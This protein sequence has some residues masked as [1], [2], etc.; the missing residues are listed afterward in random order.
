[1]TVRCTAH[2]SIATVL[3][4][5]ALL[6]AGSVSAQNCMQ[7][8]EPND[9]P[10]TANQLSDPLCVWGELADTDQDAF[11][12]TVSEEDA[13]RL[14]RFE[15]QSVPGQLTSVQVLRVEFAANGTD[16][17]DYQELF[18]VSTADGR[19][20]TSAPRLFPA[21]T[22][23]LGL[24]ISGGQGRYTLAL[25]GDEA[26][27]DVAP[28]RADEDGPVE[29]EGEFSYA[30][31]IDSSLE[32]DWTVSDEDAGYLWRTELSAAAGE[33]LNF[34]LFSPDGSQ[35]LVMTSGEAGLASV[36]S[37]GLEPGVHRLQVT[38][39]G[40]RVAPLR[41]LVARQGIATDGQEIE[42]NDEAATAN[43]LVPGQELSGTINAGGDTDWFSFVVDQEASATLFNLETSADGYL[44]L[45]LRQ[46][47]GTDVQCR[48]AEGVRLPELL[49]PEGQYSLW[50]RNRN[51]ESDIL[52]T[53]LLDP[54]GAPEEDGE[55]EPNDSMLW[56]TDIPADLRLRG[57][58]HGEETD[59]F[60]LEVTGEPQLWRA[61]VLGS[62][63]RELH[64]QRPAGG[65]L[66][67]ARGGSGPLQL[68]NLLL[69]PGT[70]YFSVK[71]SSGE[72]AFR[73][74]QLGPPAEATPSDSPL[75][76]G[77]VAEEVQAETEAQA[78]AE[79]APEPP[80]LNVEL[81]PNDESGYATP[82]EL[83]LPISG[84]V[85][86]PEDDDYFRFHLSAAQHVGLQFTPPPDGNYSLALYWGSSFIGD[87]RNIQEIPFSSSDWLPAGDYLLLVSSDSPSR[88]YYELQLERLDPFS[89]A[90][91]RETAYPEW[92]VYREDGEAV[93]GLLAVIPEVAGLQ[94]ELQHSSASPAAAY[95]PRSQQLELQLT[96]VNQADAE[97]ELQLDWHSSDHRWSLELPDTIT[98]PA[99]GQEQLSVPLLIDPDARDQ[100]VVLTV[101]ARDAAGA[102][103]T[104]P[105][106]LRA[107]GIAEPVASH[108]TWP[109]PQELL[110]GLNAAWLDLGA[111]L[112]L[113]GPG[114][115]EMSSRFNLLEL[116]N[117]MT[118][119]NHRYYN[120]H[121]PGWVTAEY[122]LEAFLPTVRLAGEE[123]VEVAG[124]LLHP[125]T[126]EALPAALRDFRVWLSPDGI[127]YVNVLEGSL[128]AEQIEQAFVLPEPVLARYA[129][130]EMHNNHIP[131]S[132]P[133]DGGNIRLGTFKV[134][135][136]LESAR[137]VAGS[138]G[139]NLA[140]P[141]LGGHLVWSDPPVIAH[142]NNMLRANDDRYVAARQD[143]EQE[144][145]VW[146]IAFHHNRA[147]QV[148]EFHWLDN[149]D[150]VGG[151][152][153]LHFVEIS[154]ST[155]GPDGPWTDLGQWVL[156][157]EDGQP[158]PF[159][160][161]EPAWARF[162]RFRATGLVP[163]GTYHYADE[164][165]VIERL[166]DEE[167]AS[168]LGEWGHYSSLGLFEYLQGQ[169]TEAATLVSSNQTRDA[170]A[171]LL[172]GDTLQGT[173][174][175][176]RN[177]A[178]Y[179]ITVP[180]DRNHLTVTL[181]GEP[182]RGFDHELL[183]SAGNHV[184]TEELASPT[185]LVLSGSVEPGEYW[186][187]IF[188]PP[189]SV[190]ISWDTSGS[191]AS[192]RPI[193]YQALARFAAD[194]SPGVEEVNL[195]PFD[196]PFL[197]RN[198]SGD[199]LQVLQALNDDPRSTS[200]SSGEAAL[201]T[202]TLA[203][204][205]RP[206]KKAVILLT[207]AA[208]GRVNELWQAL[209]S[210]SPQVFASS[211]SSSGAFGPNPPVEQD[212]M[213]DYSSV[214]GGHYEYVHA[215]ADF[216]VTF[217]RA[218]AWLRRPS[219]YQVSVELDQRWAN[220]SAWAEPELA[221]AL[222]LGLIPTALLGADLTGPITRAEFAAVA[223]RVYESLTGRP[224]VPVADNPFTDTADPEV[225]KAFN[226]ELAVGISQTEFAPDQLLNREQ[227]AT[228]LTRVFKRV[229]LPGWTWAGDADFVLDFEQPEVFADDELISPWARE[230]VY[231][232]A[233][234]GIITGTGNNQ[235]R[236]RAAS[237]Q[238]EAL[239]AANATREQALLLAV[240]LVD[241]EQ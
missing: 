106:T 68:D 172:P 33:E 98:V 190:V 213:Q 79:V 169:T 215:Q 145:S 184:V 69:L 226:T 154:V 170:A 143:F 20:V 29:A 241:R 32:F 237:P 219:H 59:F 136:T 81:E 183:D 240:R 18:E 72:Y 179:L 55:A 142:T 212:L 233:S 70:H 173:V 90:P 65:I 141:D 206:G 23:H 56:A 120:Y 180:Q 138:Q 4:F 127:E 227:A 15:L 188:E 224:A 144:D 37:L 8:Q 229:N 38:A 139:L 7:E 151:D 235:F 203:L 239:G 100:P 177:E 21:G 25:L 101:R 80:T 174:Q 135:T 210:V 157:G 167:Y 124:F 118:P 103:I 214:N 202:A 74:F 35:L 155:A 1:M 228:I 149:P 83:G 22:Y 161:A 196:S 230:S 43:I 194:I 117:G 39:P 197:I 209:R 47:D 178:W 86:S 66:A 63:V 94:L 46:A 67:S 48:Q 134:V 92:L 87:R 238:E 24:S 187:R 36:S 78:D 49:L 77:A 115:E 42:P 62:G 232:M 128:S 148:S 27:R 122:G 123:P 140:D 198:F 205:D 96:A 110:G 175:L 121:L 91:G 220:A 10:A 189:R 156:N 102:Q 181:T 131:G 73:L 168:A 195:L 147:A 58:L 146:V 152:R 207:D 19:L 16:V 99:G 13:M 82:L 162:V 153:Q 208:I 231:Y 54:V 160:L 113:D 159:I 57:Q 221:R 112:A 125:Q 166:P 88:D 41:L 97:L 204:A 76:V 225:L 129:R 111:E 95:W 93:D 137:T 185:E 150:T 3:M 12:W 14:W 222:E 108:L 26:S 17:T 9:T 44:E 75:S 50:I 30:G 200:S 158:V 132:G 71:G 53:L 234:R 192:A 2:S 119:V 191:V 223:V 105:L 64:Y 186:L 176:E 165:R 85:S 182:N 60:R 114:E 6:L 34:T 216:D 116:F 84:I 107:D 109:V 5:L 126:S 217:R 163:R 28:L 89:V 104:A 40:D 45:C 51:S 211:I 199:P 133:G 11:L 31:F 164:L 193:I 236:P 201:L 61:H 130:L 218:A 52:Y 171:P